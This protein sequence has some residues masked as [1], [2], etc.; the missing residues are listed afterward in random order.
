MSSWI[1]H[2]KPP[3]LKLFDDS[4]AFFNIVSGRPERKKKA[5]ATTYIATV[6]TTINIEANAIP[7]V[8]WQ[9]EAL[10]R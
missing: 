3:T 9:K 8:L 4:F 6:W 10:P 2:R 5:G 1:W 7:R